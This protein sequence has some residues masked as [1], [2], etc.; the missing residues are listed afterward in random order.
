VKYSIRREVFRRGT[1]FAGAEEVYV[2]AISSKSLRYVAS[3]G[4]GMANAFDVAERHFVLIREC[5]L[6]HLAYCTSPL[7]AT[8]G[9]VGDSDELASKTNIFCF[10]PSM[11]PPVCPLRC[12]PAA[13][14]LAPVPNR[15]TTSAPYTQA[16]L[17]AVGRA[18]TGLW[19]HLTCVCAGCAEGS[20]QRCTGWGRGSEAAPAWVPYTVQRA[21][22]AA[23][24]LGDKAFIAQFVDGMLANTN[25]PEALVPQ[26]ASFIRT[27][28]RRFNGEAKARAYVAGRLAKQR[29]AA[30]APQSD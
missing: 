4:S 13:V 25:E 16:T 12:K 15:A 24:R 3:K 22:P 28:F 19:R 26:V 1:A 5:D 20:G 14:G 18:H 9:A 23:G 30:A 10:R 11:N 7:F 27:A 17:N 29:A 8:S 21:P 6:T 2:W